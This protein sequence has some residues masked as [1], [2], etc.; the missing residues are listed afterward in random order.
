MSRNIDLLI[1][2]SDSFT[3]KILEDILA[4]ATKEKAKDV[5]ILSWDFGEASAKGDSYLSTVSRILVKGEVNGKSTEVK[6]VVKSLPRNLGRRK[7][8]RSADF[9]YNEIT[10]YEEVYFLF[11]FMHH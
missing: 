2:V 4:K 1:S 9:F 5:K 3:E 10:F 8:F 7:T 11:K 6:L